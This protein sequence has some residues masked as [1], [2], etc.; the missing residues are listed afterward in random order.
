MAQKRQ[1]KEFKSLTDWEHVHEIQ[2]DAKEFI[3]NNDINVKHI[4]SAVDIM[5]GG[6]VKRTTTVIY[7]L[8][9][10]ITADGADRL[11][12]SF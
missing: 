5:N 7:T 3:K 1:M 11:M 8:R 6:K 10:K 2:N 4:N 12:K 9:E